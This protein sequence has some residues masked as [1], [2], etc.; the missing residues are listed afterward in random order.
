MAI[1]RVNSYSQP[2]GFKTRA[3]RK[4]IRNEKKRLKPKGTARPIRLVPV[5]QLP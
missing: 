5:A 2:R 3:L 1:L 4:T